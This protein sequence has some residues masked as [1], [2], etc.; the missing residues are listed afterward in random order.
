MLLIGWTIWVLLVVEASGN[1]DEAI[2]FDPPVHY[3]Q[4][5]IREEGGLQMRMRIQRSF[6]PE[7]MTILFLVV[8]LVISWFYRV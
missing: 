8:I 6:T 1:A 4:A 5:Y 3:T 2:L 7:L